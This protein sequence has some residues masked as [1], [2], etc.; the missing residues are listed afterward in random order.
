MADPFSAVNFP[1][2]GRI[3]EFLLFAATFSRVAAESAVL[4]AHTEGR[5]A[6][7]FSNFTGAD[8]SET[9][10]DEVRLRAVDMWS[11][12]STI[13]VGRIRQM[14]I[15]DRIEDR[16]QLKKRGVATAKHFL[17]LDHETKNKF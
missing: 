4:R 13:C 9:D 1:P 10:T 16:L 14:T 3:A 17:N 2:L 7:G 11:S 8:P 12:L 5:G 6:L 15:L